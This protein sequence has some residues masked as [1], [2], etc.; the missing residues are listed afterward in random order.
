MIPRS[1]FI[2]KLEELGFKLDHRGRTADYYMRAGDLRFE[3]VT[4][5]DQVPEIKVRL[6]LAYAGMSRDAIEHW[7]Q[8]IQ[9]RM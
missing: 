3:T 5:R 1:H 2:A 8:S 6:A 4:L 7:I 9:E